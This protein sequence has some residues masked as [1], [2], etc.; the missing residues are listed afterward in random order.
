MSVHVAHEF[1][2]KSLILAGAVI[3][4]TIG[5]TLWLAY[6]LRFRA[7]IETSNAR[8]ALNT[9]RAEVMKKA[10][11]SLYYLYVDSAFV[12]LCVDGYDLLARRRVL[13]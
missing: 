2:R 10:L 11:K 6:E 13:Y 9:F 8:I 3:D 1:R 7:L 4:S 5:V 12:L